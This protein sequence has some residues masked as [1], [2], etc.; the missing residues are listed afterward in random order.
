MTG[1]LLV[2]D[3]LKKA[4]KNGNAD[5]KGQEADSLKDK[6]KGFHGVHPFSLEIGPT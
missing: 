5:H 1:D 2:G 6:G 4:N 3:D